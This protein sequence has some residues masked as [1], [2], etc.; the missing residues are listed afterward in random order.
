[1]RNCTLIEKRRPNG[2]H[3]ALWADN[4]GDAWY[5]EVQTSDDYDTDP[6]EY[7][8][9]EEAK[10]DFDLNCRELANQPNWDAQDAYD[11]AHGTINGYAPH[12]YNREY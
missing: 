9:M 3:V 10:A 2:F 8:T 11:D 12:Q 1:M 4:G 6:C 5:V 7:E